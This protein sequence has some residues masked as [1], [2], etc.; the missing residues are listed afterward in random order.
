MPVCVALDRD[1]LILD[2]IWLAEV[3]AVQ[4]RKPVGFVWPDA[5]SAALEGLVRAARTWDPTRGGGDFRSFAA[6]RMRWAIVDGIRQASP[7]RTKRGIGAPPWP[8]PFWELP[9]GEMRSDESEPEEVVIVKE[10]AIE[11][12]TAV[13]ALPPR[14]QLVI[15]RYFYE[16]RTLTQIGAELGVTESRACQLMKLA[17]KKLAGALA[18]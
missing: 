16:D 1:Q 3:L 12:R 15:R 5:R 6:Q 2:H 13:A 11:V 7:W 8:V 10:E 4:V 17:R 18:A 14:L 9:T